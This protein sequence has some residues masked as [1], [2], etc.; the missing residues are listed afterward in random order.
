MPK[1][2]S[3]DMSDPIDTVTPIS[4]LAAPASAPSD[5]PRI[6]VD[7]EKYAHFLENEDLTDDE[8]RAFIQALWSIIVDFV[9]LGFGV[10]PLQQTRD[11]PQNGPKSLPSDLSD[12]VTWRHSSSDEGTSDRA[13][14]LGERDRERES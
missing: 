5:R 6:L 1:R 12:V 7:Y 13:S 8:K 11:D 3:I 14:N 9:S 4:R 10:H 2:K